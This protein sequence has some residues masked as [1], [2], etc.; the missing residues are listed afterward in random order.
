MEENTYSANVSPSLLVKHYD[1]HER[2][3]LQR[4][5]LVAV[6]KCEKSSST[7]EH[8]QA[9][10]KLYSRATSKEIPAFF[11]EIKVKHTRTYCQKENQIE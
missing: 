1:C 11:C 8:Y 3:N 4:Y 7:A 9:L 6:D 5:N 10:V 2:K